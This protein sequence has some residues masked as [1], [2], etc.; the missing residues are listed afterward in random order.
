MRTHVL[1]KFDMKQSGFLPA[2]SMC[3]QCMPAWND[4]DADS[5]KGDNGY[6]HRVVQGQVGCLHQSAS[7]RLRSTSLA[8]LCECRWPDMST[9]AAA[10]SDHS[11]HLS[12][13]VSDQNAY[14]LGGIAGHAG[15]FANILELAPL[16]SHLLTA[17]VADPWINATTV[18][19]FTTVSLAR[20][21]LTRRA[22]LLVWHDCT[23]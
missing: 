14:A 8:L 13:Q 12:P 2:P 17:E 10:F 21:A 16:V 3:A 1:A 9:V 6:R 23:V 20:P 19:T 15:L 4:T 22:S 5:P 7:L 18:R 11:L